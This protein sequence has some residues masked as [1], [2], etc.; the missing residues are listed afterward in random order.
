M[1]ERRDVYRG[2]VGRPERKRRLGRPKWEN[3][4]KMHLQDVGW[5]AWTTL[6]WLTIQTGG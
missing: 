1:G 2:L 6:I 5:G 4:I 3:N